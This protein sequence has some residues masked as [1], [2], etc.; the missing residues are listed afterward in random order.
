MLETLHRFLPTS[1]ESSATILLGWALLV[2]FVTF[3]PLPG[4]S[5][6]SLKLSWKELITSRD[7]RLNILDVFRV[8]AIFWVMINHT[9]SE[10]RVDILER[11]PSAD[12]FKHAVHEHPIFGPL[13]GNSALGVEIFLVLS[14]LLAL[15][16]WMRLAERPFLPH[17][18]SF[19]FRRLLRLFPS[20]AVF[21]FIAA[22][23]IPRRFL[24]RYHDT[25]I[26]SCGK[27][28]ILAH[29]TFL[30]N[31]Q[32]TP[33]CMGYLWYLGLDMQLYVLC[34]F[35][36]HLLYK[37]PRFGVQL[38]A[39]LTV[40]VA[41]RA[42]YCRT[43]GFCNNSDVDIP[44]ISFPNQTAES[45]ASIYGGIWELYARPYGKCGPFLLGMLL[46]YSTLHVKGSL[47]VAASKLIAA[48]S[49][50][51]AVAVIYAIEP[52]YWFPDQG[53]TLYNTVYTATFRT[54]FAAAI[55]T[56]IAALFYRTEPV[57]LSVAWSAL[58]KLTFNAYLLHM[59]TVYLMNYSTFLQ[60]A[61]GPLRLLAVLPLVAT[62]SYT[63]AFVFFCFVESPMGRISAEVAKTV[64]L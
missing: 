11:K 18:V 20:V 60:E 28:G 50:L 27:A 4:L 64:G 37:R 42:V 45:L 16:S 25:M 44:F 55:C 23:P 48:V 61:T 35:L 43:Y 51:V 5:L 30:G 29:L 6:L 14:G 46:G 15:R 38:I 34:P 62:I 52:E 10:G 53:N 8:I 9:G 33:T 2:V 59:G 19:I 58:A 56:F 1:V 39:A 41:I 7:S 17:Y 31:W 63:T 21:V 12:A 22:G 57:H 3:L 24:P 13:L 40:S 26:S 54:V 32:K 47:S 49:L 36:I